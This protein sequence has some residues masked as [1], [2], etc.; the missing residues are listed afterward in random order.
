M[1]MNSLDRVLHLRYGGLFSSK[2]TRVEVWVGVLRGAD[3]NPL[4]RSSSHNFWPRFRLSLMWQHIARTQ[5]HLGRS[6]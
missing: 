3:A 4:G 2:C 5:R 1:V 6:M